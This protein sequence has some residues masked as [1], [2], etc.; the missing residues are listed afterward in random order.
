MHSSSL[1]SSFAQP[2]FVLAAVVVTELP[3]PGDAP[4]ALANTAGG[5]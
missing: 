3:S 4:G 5:S 1:E 2:S